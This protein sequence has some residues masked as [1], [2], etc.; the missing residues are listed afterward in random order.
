MRLTLLTAAAI[1]TMSVAVAQAENKNNTGCGLGTMLFKGKSGK[2][3]EVLAVTTN[4]TSSN[5]TFAISSGTSGCTNDG[6]V[7]PP[8][9]AAAFIDANLD[10]LARDASRGEGESLESLAELMG[11]QEQDK[12]IFFEV[13]QRNFSTVFASPD[14]TAN[15]VLIS[16]YRIMSEDEV[17]S[18]YA[19]A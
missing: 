13:T 2:G 4:G 14:T 5:Q 17:L 15:D 11:I 18:R 16:W 7:D 6:V 1:L 9:A 12:Q 3:S 10:K 8:Q 19:G